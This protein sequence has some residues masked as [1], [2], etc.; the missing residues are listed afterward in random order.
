M[1]AASLSEKPSVS[2]VEIATA[3]LQLGIEMSGQNRAHRAVAHFA[4][5]S[6]AGFKGQINVETVGYVD[7]PGAEQATKWIN[8]VIFSMPRSSPKAK[9]EHLV[10]A[11]EARRR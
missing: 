5:L 1:S 2:T 8:E 10:A 9:V 7:G 4:Y 6:A 11:L 3:F